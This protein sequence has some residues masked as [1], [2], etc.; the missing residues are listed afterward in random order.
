MWT[1]ELLFDRLCQFGPIDT[2]SCYGHIENAV[3]IYNAPKW[4]IAAGYSQRWGNWIVDGY[5]GVW[6]FTTNSDFWSRNNY[7]PGTQTQSQSPIGAVEGHLSRSFKPRLWASLDG[8]LW[9]GGK[10]SLNGV[11]NSQTRQTNSRLGATLA[12]P[13]TK[14]QSLKFSYS[15]GTYIRYGGNYQHVSVAWQ[16]SWLGKPK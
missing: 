6:F 15:D 4:W 16:Y 8:N 7:Y 5:F 11:P 14:H 1:C 12:V 2:V 9:F 10:T 13:I 3:D